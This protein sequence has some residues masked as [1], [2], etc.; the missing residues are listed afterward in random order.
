MENELSDFR[1]KISF[2]FWLFHSKVSLLFQNKSVLIIKVCVCVNK[3]AP[4][5]CISFARVCLWVVKSV[6]W[7][8]KKIVDS[9]SFPQLNIESTISEKFCLNLCSFSLLNPTPRQV[10][11]FILMSLCSLVY[12][13]NAIWNRS[14]KTQ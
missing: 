4:I 2:K 1:I 8:R 5:K 6:H 14:N 9:M 10:K 12:P 11:K 3:F 13:A 7:R